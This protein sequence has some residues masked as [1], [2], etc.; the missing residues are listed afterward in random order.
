ME[1]LDVRA[2]AVAVGVLWASY[3]VQLGWIARFGW[4]EDLQE[5]LSSLYVGYRPTF[6]GSLVGGAWG[7]LDGFLAGGVIALVYNALSG[8]SAEETAR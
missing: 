2:T 5:A 6:L 8:E 3:V 4:G 7:F 1:K